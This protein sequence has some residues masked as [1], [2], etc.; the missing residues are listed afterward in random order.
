MAQC[1]H[2]SSHGER[3]TRK[4]HKTGGHFYPG[5]VDRFTWRDGDIQIVEGPP[6][7]QT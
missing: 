4:A 1:Q 7:G 5:R 6:N 3:C 2:R